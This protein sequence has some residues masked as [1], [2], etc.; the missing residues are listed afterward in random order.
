MERSYVVPIAGASIPS[1]ISLSHRY[2]SHPKRHPA[3]T[4]TTSAG[5]MGG[6]GMLPHANDLHVRMERLNLVV[7]CNESG[8][9]EG[10]GS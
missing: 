5:T 8:L 1:C 4:Q 7:I 9:S 10:L 3:A 6:K 2:S